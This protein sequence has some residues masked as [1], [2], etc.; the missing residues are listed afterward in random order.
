VSLG[1]IDKFFSVL[2]KSLEIQIQFERASAQL[3]STPA[4]F[5]PALAV[6]LLKATLW[7]GKATQD[8]R[9]MMRNCDELSPCNVDD[10]AGLLSFLGRRY[11]A[12]TARACTD[13]YVSC[14]PDQE[15]T[16]AQFHVVSNT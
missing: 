16:H 15:R 2:K 14:I 6:I 12:A 10:L 3:V 7:L 4:H 1:K 9:S 11:E 13:S 5:K 8:R